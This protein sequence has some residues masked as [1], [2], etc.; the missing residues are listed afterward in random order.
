[1]SEFNQNDPP[2]AVSRES[3]KEKEE[4]EKELNGIKY[5]LYRESLYNK[6]GDPAIFVALGQGG[7]T[8]KDIQEILAKENW[9]IQTTKILSG[10]SDDEGIV[11][12]KSEK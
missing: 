2:N 7:I 9:D 5:S 1:M 12:I 4:E 8:L 10:F 6:N 3:R 11:L